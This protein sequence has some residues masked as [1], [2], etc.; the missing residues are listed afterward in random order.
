MRKRGL[1]VERDDEEEASDDL[2]RPALPVGMVCEG[3]PMDG[4]AY[5]AE[6]RREASSPR[7]LVT[8]APDVVSSPPRARAPVAHAEPS[9]LEPLDDREA[10]W[11]GAFSG[12]FPRVRAQVANT[13][14]PSTDA[15]VNA[16]RVGFRGVT[17]ALCKSVFEL[18][19]LLCDPLS[20][21]VQSD[22]QFLARKL[23]AAPPDNVSARVALITLSNRLSVW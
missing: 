21:E 10:Q 6:V 3:E 15:Q 18:S 13:M 4:L 16:L 2:G 22:L 23:A 12:S 7:F 5:L 1:V 19:L 17:E 14:E 9:R 11:A 20:P 8:I